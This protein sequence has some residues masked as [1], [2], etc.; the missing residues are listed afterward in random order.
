MN[1]IMEMVQALILSVLSSIG[2]W[3]S[4]KVKEYFDGLKDK[5]MKERISDVTDKVVESVEAYSG[6]RKGMDKF[7]FAIGM[8]TEILAEEGIK[9]NPKLLEIEVEDGVYKLNTSKKEKPIE[10]N[11]DS[12]KVFFDNV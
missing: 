1:E 6:G 11:V 12:E 5:R 3:I 2:I 4:L 9:T 10:N 8:A 7:H